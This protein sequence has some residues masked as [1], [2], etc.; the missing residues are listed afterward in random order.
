MDSCAVVAVRCDLTELKARKLS[1]GGNIFVVYVLTGSN[2][3]LTACSNH[4][5]FKTGFG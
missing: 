3:D 4:V 2:N 5:K 1:K